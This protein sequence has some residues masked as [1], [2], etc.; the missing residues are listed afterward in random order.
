MATGLKKWDLL[1]F[2]PEPAW[3]PIA[4]VAAR[5]RLAEIDGV[6]IIIIEYH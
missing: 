1:P 3:L 6:I 2:L 4:D 5:R